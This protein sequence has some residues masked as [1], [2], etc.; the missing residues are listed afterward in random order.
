MP[1]EYPYLLIDATHILGKKVDDSSISDGYVLKYNSASSTIIYAPDA[2]GGAASGANVIFGKII[3]FEQFTGN[4]IDNTFTLTGTIQ[5]GTFDTGAWESS[6]IANTLQSDAVSTTDAPI[7]DSGNIFTR[8]RIL[9]NS[10][11]TT[12]GLV[13]LSHIPQNLASFRIYYWYTLDAADI[14]EDYYRTDYVTEFE[15]SGADIASSVSLNTSNLADALSASETTVQLAFDRIDDYTYA[16]N[17]ATGGNYRLNN[18]VIEDNILYYANNAHT[19]GATFAGDLANWTAL[20]VLYFDELFDVNIPTPVHGDVIFYGGTSAWEALNSGIS[21]YFLKTQGINADPIWAQVDHGDLTGLSDDDHSQYALL[22]GRAG[23]QILIGGTAA[24]DDLTLKTT[25]DAAKGTYFL[26]DLTSDGLIKTSGGT[27]ALSIATGGTDYEFPL[28]FSDGLSRAVNA[29]TNTDKGSSAVATHEATYVHSDIALNTAARHSAA[30]VADTTTI[31][32]SIT[33]QQISGAVIQSG[34][35]HG[36]I[37]G[38]SDDDHA[39]YALLAGRAGGQILVGGTAAGDDLTL[40]TTANAAKGTYFLTDLASNGLIKTSGGT[41]ALSIATA[42]TDYQQVVTWGDGLA[43]SAPTASIDYNT[44]NL[45][46]TGGQIDT[47]QS[48][49]TSASPTFANLTDSGLTITRIPFASTGGL[50]VDSASMVFDTTNGIKLAAGSASALNLTST[51]GTAVGG[52]LFGADVTLYR[53]AANVLKTDD[54]LNVVGD[55]Y[56]SAITDYSA[57]STVVGWSSFTT[58]DIRYKKIG[59]TVFVWYSFNGTS[60]STTTTFTLPFTAGL[61]ATTSVPQALTMDNGV[62]EAVGICYLSNG[63]STVNLRRNP[64]SVLF[65]GSGQKIC[66]GLFTFEA[67]A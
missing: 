18:I 30:T 66:F 42:D 51:A 6:S 10:I 32:M 22:A 65:T 16:P 19:A 17:W 25:S 5:N 61:G 31:D 39:Q 11:N 24:G 38:L 20:G 60:D 34:L 57:T 36:S 56:T 64:G 7:Y 4:G 23:G 55:V 53:S 54:A 67:N 52:I 45:K 21:G 58:K 43:Y 2:T 15:K 44:T 14:I 9:V 37:G 47:I 33:G 63:S 29:V 28:T 49:A 27:G 41:G 59:K 40:H 35:D 3:F 62:Y 26:T 8:N 1:I 50:L 13:T 12:S 46:I 48:I